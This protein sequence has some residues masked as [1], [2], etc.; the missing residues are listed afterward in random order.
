MLNRNITSLFL[1]VMALL[2]G[3]LFSSQ[4]QAKPNYGLYTSLINAYSKQF[5]ALTAEKYTWDKRLFYTHGL[6]YTDLKDLDGDGT[7]E[8]IL[9]RV[10][11]NLHKYHGSE[12]AGLNTTERKS[13]QV[14]TISK[15]GMLMHLGTLRPLITAN[16]MPGWFSVDYTTVNGKNYIINGSDGNYMD[17]TFW[18]VKDYSLE[19]AMR[20]EGPW[21]DGLTP[22][23]HLNNKAVDEATYKKAKKEWFAK[24]SSI[25]LTNF[26]AQDLDALKKHNSTVQKKLQKYTAAQGVTKTAN[27]N[28]EN[29]V[30]FEDTPENMQEK[31]VQ[32]FYS[33]VIMEDFKAFPKIIP[34]I[35]GFDMSKYTFDFNG[36]RYLAQIDDPAADMTKT[37]LSLIESINPRPNSY[38]P[39]KER[40]G[41]IIEEFFTFD[42]NQMD[43][44]ARSPKAAS[45]E[46]NRNTL[47]YT[48]GRLGEI[49][50]YS[51]KYEYNL[52][53]YATVFVTVRHKPTKDKPSGIDQN[54]FLVGVEEGQSKWKIYD[55]R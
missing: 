43:Y 13:L 25:A 29:F 7:D 46:L 37:A 18:H 40:Y 41:Y 10:L 24:E 6:I 28:G 44:I 31:L 12:Y 55:I 49:F 11:K 36:M 5:G 34:T 45:V 53:D 9:V 3:M 39:K 4:A 52:E 1:C 26:M 33:A 14:F 20:I 51:A 42:K 21:D 2:G 30:I 22:R 27:F 38:K 15:A 8:L 16:D 35:K 48:F 23:Y 19:P 50:N 47:I 32:D 54:W 17:K